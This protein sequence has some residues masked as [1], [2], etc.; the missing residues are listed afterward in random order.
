MV[1]FAEK[2]SHV[3]LGGFVYLSLIPRSR[4]LSQQYSVTPEAQTTKQAED[5][6]AGGQHRYSLG[7]LTACVN[8]KR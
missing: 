3:T 8:T 6:G 7:S 2:F 4:S 5:T 1:S